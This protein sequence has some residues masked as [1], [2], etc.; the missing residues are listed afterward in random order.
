MGRIP[1]ATAARH[2]A[3]WAARTMALVALAWTLTLATSLAIAVTSHHAQVETLARAEAQAN[4][5]KDLTFRRWATTHGGVYVPIDENTPPNP[6]LHVP[7]R[8]ITTP[9]GTALTLMNPAYMLRQAMQ[10][11][12]ELYGIKGRITS[13]QLTNPANAPDEWERAALERFKAG[14]REISEFTT[15]E[16]QPALRVMRAMMMERG[17]LK[18]HAGTGVK[19]GE[20]RGGIGV[21][22]P[23]ARYQDLIG[24]QTVESAMSHAALWLGGMAVIAVVGR[25]HIRM[26]QQRDRALQVLAASEERYRT[27]VETAQEGVWILDGHGVTVYV[28]AVIGRWLG[29]PVEALV[30]RPMADFLRGGGGTDFVARALAGPDRTELSLRGADGT[31]LDL[32]VSASPLPA[33]DG[34]RLL[35]MVS[36]VTAVK[37]SEEGL[38][39]VVDQLLDTNSDLERFA[40]AAAHDLREPLRTIISFCQLLDL[41]HGASLDADARELIGYIVSGAHRMDEVI[42]DLRRYAE[43]SAAGGPFV[44]VSLGDAIQGAVARLSGAIAEAGAR[45]DV[46]PQLPD[47]YGD[48]DQLA[49]IFEEVL[50]NALKYRSGEPPHIV[51]T[52]QATEDEVEVTVADNGIGIAAEYHGQV[53]AI[54]SRLHPPGRYSGTGMGLALVRRV[55]VRHGGRIRLASEPGQGTVV[56]ITLPRRP[57]GV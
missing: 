50:T 30:G 28:N 37:R 40:H 43:I 24:E 25:R 29:Q 47:V 38:R 39:R 42:E 13:L 17:C 57:A 4:L 3:K 8:D 21:N 22:I 1:G 56:R 36:D 55:V 2:N 20:V 41:R 44:A 54:F 46:A 18:C 51:V 11:F 53:F 32:L 5:D 35:C 10:Q 12:G 52:A 48:A 7:D 14:E 33:E 6:Y 31:T 16:G 19:E 26:A 27:I 34:P 9:S 23:L 45:V 15:M 49:M